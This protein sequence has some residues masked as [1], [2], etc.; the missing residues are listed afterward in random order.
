MKFEYNDGGRAAAGF[1][2]KTGDCVTRAI[3]IAAQRP[4][5][6]IYDALG[7]GCR[8]ENKSKKRSARSGVHTSRK[9]FKDYM[10]KLGFEW[11]PCMTIGSGCRVHLTDGELPMGRLVVSVSRHF[12]A[13]IDGVIHDTFNP[14]RNVV[15]LV[16]DKTRI[17]KRC[18]YGYY[19]FQH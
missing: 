9:W 19:K 2:G 10:K 14:E 12:T 17:A 3:A 8:N 7:E 4:Y 11:T 13:V 16:G 6:E 5:Q 1:K 18:V 15:I